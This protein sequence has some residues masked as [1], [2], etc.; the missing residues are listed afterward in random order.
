MPILSAQNCFKKGL[1][2]LVSGS[3]REAADLFGQAIE[4]ERQ[5]GVERLDARYLSYYGLCRAKSG[6]PD[7]EALGACQAAGELSDCAEIH[8][9]LGRVWL[10]CGNTQRAL[11]SFRHGAALDP[12]HEGIARKLS[13]LDRRGRD[14]GRGRG[15]TFRARRLWR[16]TLDSISRRPAALGAR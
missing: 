10:L 3:Y 13:Q 9:N 12:G 7:A 4:I 1:I 8:F 15:L 2:A 5:R 11:A 6:N 16:R 14:R